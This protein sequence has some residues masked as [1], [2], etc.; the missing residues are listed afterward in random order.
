MNTRCNCT[1]ER[2]YLETAKLRGDSRFPAQ[3]YQRYSLNDQLLTCLCGRTAA[4]RLDVDDFYESFVREMPAI[5]PSQLIRSDAHGTNQSTVEH[6]IW[7]CENWLREAE[8]ASLRPSIPVADNH[9]RLLPAFNHVASVRHS[10]NPIKVTRCAG[11]G[12]TYG[13]GLKVSSRSIIP[14]YSSI[15]RVYAADYRQTMYLSSYVREPG[16][17][18]RS[19]ETAYISSDQ[20]FTVIC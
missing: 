10:D 5:K 13:V 20:A 11:S 8:A 9:R 2:N 15:H 12:H 16:F 7:S 14:D 19:K 6:L 4:N 1:E 3:H 18:R 17:G